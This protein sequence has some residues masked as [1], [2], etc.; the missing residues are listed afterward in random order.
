MRDEAGASCA[1]ADPFKA[2]RCRVNVDKVVIGAN[3]QEVAIRREL[4]LVNDLL[5]VLYV[6]HLLQ[7][8]GDHSLTVSDVCLVNVSQ[9]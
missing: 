2:L 3:R 6:D 7:I 5:A 8:P 9:L 1:L 4:H